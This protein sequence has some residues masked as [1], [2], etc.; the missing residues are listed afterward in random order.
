[1]SAF[2]N[3]GRSERQKFIDVTGCFRPEAAVAGLRSNA[4]Y[5]LHFRGIDVMLILRYLPII[6]RPDVANLAVHFLASL[7]V[8]RSIPALNCHN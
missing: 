2:T 1:M 6:N 3:S 7:T 4:H 8:F 5:I